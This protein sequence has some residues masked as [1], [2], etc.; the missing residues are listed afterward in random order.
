MDDKTTMTGAQVH[1]ERL[2]DW[3][4]LLSTLT[5][6]LLTGDF[7]TGAGLVAAI[8]EAAEESQHH[9]DLDLRYPHL[10]VTLT[11]HDVGGLT[12]RD[13][14]MAR[15]ISALAAEHGVSA[16]P[17][18]LSTLELALDTAD[19]TRV[20]PFWAALLGSETGKPDEVVDSSGRLP[21]LWFQSAEPGEVPAQRFHYDLHVPHDVARARIEAALAAGG[22]MVDDAEAP[23][24]WILADADG[25]RACVCTW[26]GRD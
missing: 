10:D 16:D 6:R 15:T 2:D 26:Q 11:S 23:S 22:T 17:T 21:S 20:R 18:Q 9:P 4:Q 12:Q 7:V 8:T 19:L 3:R 14:R 25:N 1:A 5:T 13:V 24:F